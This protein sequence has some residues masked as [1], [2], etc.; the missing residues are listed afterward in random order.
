MWTPPFF[1]ERCARARASRLRQ[2]RHRADQRLET[3]GLFHMELESRAQHALA[4]LETGEG[5][6][7]GGRCVS[8][9]LRR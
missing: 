1:S 4:M 9:T 6:E 3:E 8:A 5:G 7:G 2:E